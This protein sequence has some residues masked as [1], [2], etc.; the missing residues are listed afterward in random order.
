MA[1]SELEA[2]VRTFLAGCADWHA[3]PRILAF[4]GGTFTGLQPELLEA[5]LCEAE[6]LIASGLI[7]GIKAST[8]PDELDAERLARLKRAGL[9]E[10]ELGAQS[11]DDR[12][13]SLSGRGHTSA[14]TCR[15]ARLIKAAG[16]QLGLQ[17]MPGLPGENRESF[18]HS[19]AVAAELKPDTFRIY[20]TVVMQGTALARSQAAGKYC[21][22]EMDEALRRSL[23]AL[24]SLEQA[25]GRCLRLG[26][27]PFDLARLVAGPYHP[28]FGERVRSL[29]FGLMAR[30]L[31]KGQTCLAVNPADVSALLGYERCNVGVLGFGYVADPAVPRGALSRAGEKA[32]LYFYDIIHEIL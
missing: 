4:Y 17:L 1:P 2:A 9:V 6:R 29:G 22:L 8:R 23:Y 24:V 32:C 31:V 21:P 18:R 12:V 26:L 13:L 14:A 10:I 16:V 30:R 5:Y 27:P 28:A 7:G 25:G 19:V 20:P 11:F 15:A 3:R